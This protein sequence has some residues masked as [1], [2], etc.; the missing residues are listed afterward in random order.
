[1]KTFFTILFGVLLSTSGAFTREPTDLEQYY[2]E[3]VNRARANPNAEVTRLSGE[4]WGDMGTPAAPNLNEGLV[5]GTISASAKQPLAFDPRLIDAADAYSQLL[6]DSEEFSHT[7]GGTTAK[8]RMEAQ[9]YTFIPASAS[10]E[11]LATT[12]STGPHPVNVE[13][14]DDHHSGLF[15]DGDVAGRGHRTNLMEPV[16]REVGIAILPDLDGQSIFGP[17]FNDVLSTQDFATSSGRVFITGVVYNDGNNNNFYDP[18]ESAGVLNLR[19]E[20]L[21][22]SQ[23]GSGTTFASGGYSINLGALA[24]GTYILV[25]EEGFGAEAEV[26]FSWTG[27]TN[28]KADFVDPFVPFRPDGRIGL[29]TTSLFGNGIYSDSAGEQGVRQTAKNSRNLVWKAVFENDGQQTDTFVLTGAAGNRLFRLT[30]LRTGP[31]DTSNDTAALIAG[32]VSGN[33]ASDESLSYQIAVK[34]NRPALGKRTGITAHLRAVSNGDNS[35]V[36]RVNA[37]L[38]NRT[39]KKKKVRRR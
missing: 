27:S 22:G 8:S 31:G 32:I 19:V 1:M 37:L 10:G 5:P 30:Y 2:L 4:T 13:R 28:V 33:V 25:L 23:V 20:T 34:P 26:Q 18:G 16:F 15:I 9:G 38:I 29:K 6:L 7:A 11:N 17:G 39:K 21:G 35:Q 36:D 3:L 24:P 12:A 14:V